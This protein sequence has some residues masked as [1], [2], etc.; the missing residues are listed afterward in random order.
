VSGESRSLPAGT[1]VGGVWRLESL[2][3]AGAFGAVFR[4]T[5]VASGER[6]AVK[7]IGLS[8][9]ESAGGA[10]RVRR[11]AELASRLAHPCSVR[12]LGSGED[13]RGFL[14]IA[15]ELLEG[16]TLEAALGARG[17]MPPSVA[18][19]IAIEVLAALGEAHALQIIHRDLKPA[20]LFAARGTDGE[21]IKVLDFGLAKSIRAG[22]MAGLTQ[23][24]GAVGTP[25][26]M[27]PEQIR[28]EAVTGK[29]DLYSLGIVLLEL[30]TGIAPLAE[31]APMIMLTQRIMG[32]RVPIPASLDGSPLK[33]IIERATDADPA[34]RFASAAEMAAALETARASLAPPPK[35]SW[36]MFAEPT[37]AMPS[38]SFVAGPTM[39]AGAVQ[40]KRS[41]RAAI[42]IVGAIAAF[43]LVTAIVLGGIAMRS[44]STEK[45]ASTR[46]SRRAPEKTHADQAPPSASSTSPPA[47]PLTARAP[48][49]FAPNIPDWLE[50]KLGPARVI[51]IEIRPTGARVLVQE[52]PTTDALWF[53]DVLEDGSVTKIVEA[54]PGGPA[55]ESMRGLAFAKIPAMIETARARAHA[56]LTAVRAVIVKVNEPSLPPFQVL[57]DVPGKNCW[58]S[59]DRQG[60][61][62]KF[63]DE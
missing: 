61:L 31:E 25:L 57:M 29:S 2:L 24:G 5:H 30:L 50:K 37:R 33:P 42:P 26:Y 40:P 49:A 23:Q 60:E 44:S 15:L 21:R 41:R 38:R 46:S 7:V 53:Y 47:P 11:E 63:Q 51:N 43:G 54:S 32:Q 62:V 55:G 52:G 36:T 22:T 39:F 12:V 4:A 19:S 1:I 9:V 13:A 8:D 45:S 10:A 58:A 18:A 34:K 6:A 14:F 27:S 56:P 35:T 3:G 20:N 59:F 16:E 48:Y 17:P 28:G